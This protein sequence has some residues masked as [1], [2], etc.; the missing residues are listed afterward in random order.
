MSL[1]HLPSDISRRTRLLKDGRSGNGPVVYWMSRDQRAADNWALLAAV[2][3][4]KALSCPLRVFFC[5]APS[6]SVASSRHYRFLAGGLRLLA[7]S[8]A[9]KNI[10]L[11]IHS[12]E[13]GISVGERANFLNA[14][15]I[16]TDF[17]PYPEKRS[18]KEDLR[19]TAVCPVAETDAHNIV[20]AWTV[21]PKKEYSAATFR[22]K[23]SPLLSGW[24]TDI[25]ETEPMPPMNMD[26]TAPFS[27]PGSF[28]V[29]QSEPGTGEPPEW[30]HP[31]ESA[32]GARLSAFLKEGLAAYALQRNDP[33]LDGLSG[34]SPWLH[35]GHLS[36]QR[37][38]FE[39]FSGGDTESSRCFLEEL[40][41]R[42]ELADNFCLYEADAGT[43]NG[44]PEWARKTLDN[45]R[46]DPRPFFYDIHAL[47]EAQTADP[48]WNAAQ[49]EMRLLGKMHGWTRMYW[50]K[51]ILEWSPSPEDAFAT[52]LFLNDRYELDGRDP[53]G[54]AGIS[55]AI[56]GLHDRPWPERTVFGTV[57]YMNYS[58]AVRKFNVIQYIEKI[59]SIRRPIQ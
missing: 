49:K 38:A 3:S 13:P 54:I 39:V 50:A 46:N 48:L 36:A 29:L 23:I 35:F 53:N 37:A 27:L 42:R 4:A 5:L 34:L 22:R 32:A 40:V 28:A 56:G 2:H 31:G 51:K 47:E 30:I 45:H 33:G 26:G 21:S 12:G 55:W 19:K 41:V 16:V 8:L 10:P 7:R 24:L 25:P 20:P 14:A 1:P 11:E 58:G 17:D 6:F 52:A 44:L 9:E 57:R 18:W 15:L 59:D 43:Y